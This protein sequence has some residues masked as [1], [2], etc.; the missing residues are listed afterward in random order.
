[1]KRLRL[2]KGICALLILIFLFNLASCSS[3]EQTHDGK[4]EITEEGLA[5]SEEYTESVTQRLSDMLNKTTDEKLKAI[6]S[7][8]KKEALAVFTGKILP[9]L[10]E[11]KVYEEELDEFFSSMETMLDTEDYSASKL[12]SLYESLLYTLGSTRTG[13]LLH[14]VATE[15]ISKKIATARDRYE[16][17]GYSWYLDDIERCES[18]KADL[19]EMGEKH[20]SEIVSAA[21]FVISTLRSASPTS[22]N[23]LALSDAE[24]LFILEH[25]GE[26]FLLNASDREDWQIVGRLITEL[27]PKLDFADST[28]I[29]ILYALKQEAYFNSLMQSCTELFSLYASLTR[30]LRSEG[31]FSLSKSYSEN[32]RAIC[33]ALLSSQKELSELYTA[34]HTS[35]SIDSDRLRRAVEECSDKEALDLFLSSHSPLTYEELKEEL[36][37]CANGSGEFKG[38]EEIMLGTLYS[39]S[40][41]LSF[42]FFG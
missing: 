19:T 32:E 28:A 5:Y 24:L 22:D 29:S 38:I 41:Y 8:N 3:E 12:T 18:L 4:L 15:I 27:I 33:S 36:S 23:A 6:V 37:T 9:K 30:N 42:I 1:M 26:E 10:C 11:I 7:M 21:A 20:F 14:T 13:I 17:Y 31:K 25:Q 2:K 40:P 39:V 34:L 35:G 16:K